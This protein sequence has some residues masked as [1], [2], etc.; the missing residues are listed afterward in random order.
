MA[1]NATAIVNHDI[2]R[3]QLCTGFV[4]GFDVF[5]HP[6]MT[7]ALVFLY[8]LPASACI[9]VSQYQ[10]IYRSCSQRDLFETLMWP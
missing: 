9:L 6:T 4:G 10:A 3:V 2:Q 1:E 8:V 5:P 7:V